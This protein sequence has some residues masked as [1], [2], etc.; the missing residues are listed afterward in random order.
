MF[1]EPR[2][3]STSN[4]CPSY[5]ACRFRFQHSASKRTFFPFPFWKIASFPKLQKVDPAKRNSSSAVP[6]LHFFGQEGGN[7]RGP[8]VLKGLLKSLPRHLPFVPRE[9]HGSKTVGEAVFLITKRFSCVDREGHPRRSHGTVSKRIL[10][11]ARLS[12]HDESL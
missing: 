4:C 10:R 2:P 8:V 7:H 1:Q 12:L 5:R 6:S 9:N 11:P 3:C